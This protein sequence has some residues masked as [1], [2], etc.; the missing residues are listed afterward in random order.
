MVDAASAALT[1]LVDPYRLTMLAMG[2]LLGLFVGLIPGIGGLTGMALLLP[3]TY[4]MDPLAAIAMLLGVTSVSNT[5]DTIPAVLFGVPG[6]SGAQ[7]TVM[8]GYPMAKRGEAGRA[9]S[10]AFTASLLGG[11]VGAFLLVL[12]IPI[13]RPVMLYVGTPE[14][15]SFSIFGIAMIAV[16]SGSA[17]MRG[18][19]AAGVGVLLS[20]IGSDP[21]TGTLRYT[22]GTFYLWD[23]LSLVPLV[24]GLFALPELADMAVKRTAIASKQRYDTRAGT[25]AGFNDTMRN[26][27]LVVRGGA[28]G[29]VI[30]CIPGLS[31]QV[32]DWIAYAWAAQSVKGGDKTF[33]TGD[34][35]G[36]I[37]PES[38]N[39]AL[40]AGALLPTVAFAVPG[41]A[42][43]ALLLSVF[44]VHGVSPGPT[45]LTT[46]LDLTFTMIW[47]IAIAN[48]LG[49]GLC[50]LFSGQLAKVASLRY[51]L[52]LPAIVVFIC[53][54]SF[55]ASR[56]WG[57]LYTLFVFAIIGWTMKH[58]RWPRPPLILGFVLGSLIERYFFISTSRYE[59]DWLTRPVVMIVLAGAVLV[60][61][62]PLRKRI[63]ELGGVRSI[64]GDFGAPKFHPRDLLYFGVFLLVGWMIL[65]SLQWRWEAS[66]GP[67]LV[68]SITLA[69]GVL[70]LANQI[71]GRTMIE[72]RVAAG[73]VRPER[74]MDT[75]IDF[76]DTDPIAVRIRIFRLLAYFVGFLFLMAAFGVIIAA[77][78]FVALFMVL[79]GRE[80]WTIV[81][82]YSIFVT[83]IV[84]L[85]FDQFLNVPWPISF[86]GQMV[87]AL[88]VIPSV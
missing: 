52:I 57:D 25:V 83:L 32:V 1:A 2:V 70:S 71:F 19:I 16:L 27:W 41:S 64:I 43:M 15:L 26:W 34:V 5:S 47:S 56:S 28:L 49:A 6:S 54:G 59:F 74:F 38:A 81:T 31:T 58:L 18:M 69:F 88:R 84:F 78:I 51:T 65:G 55:Q 33:G 10:A 44:M 77:P 3:F 73:N 79:E 68:G 9:L 13:L 24:L 22:L 80:R 87:P 8:D 37:A 21:Q 12:A 20:M 42:S 86:L 72:T 82:V 45:M 11:L 17:P 62:A 85:V 76:G 29:A 63:G 23:G 75:P 67:I 50:F 30:G 48:I 40:T 61:L 39:N 14:L 53:I 4:S 66:I 46:N 35:R 60:L 7:A 36:V